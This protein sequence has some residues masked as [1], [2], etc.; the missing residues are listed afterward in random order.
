VDTVP[1][2]T[3]QFDVFSD[4]ELVFSKKETGRFPEER[5]LLGLL[6]A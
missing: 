6:P 4:S 1:G 5:E 3:G 2:A